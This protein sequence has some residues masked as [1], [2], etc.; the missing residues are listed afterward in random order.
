MVCPERNISASHAS[1]RSNFFAA[2]GLTSALRTASRLAPQTL[3]NFISSLW[4]V[5]QRGHSIRRL[6]IK[7]CREYDHSTTLVLVTQLPSWYRLRS[8]HASGSGRNHRP[9]PDHRAHRSRGHGRGLQSLRQQTATR[10][11]VESATARIRLATGS[12]PPF[13]SG[14][15]RRVRVNTSTHPHGLRSEEHTSELQSRL[16]LVCPLL[17]E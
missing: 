4:L 5:P 6:L 12:S 10:L 14:S 17:L 9:L 11:R 16:H 1:P 7:G 2:F 15:A 8:N 13:L 3:Q